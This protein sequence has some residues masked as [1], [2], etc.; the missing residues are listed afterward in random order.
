MSSSY[1]EDLPKKR[2]SCKKQCPRLHLYDS[3]TRITSGYSAPVAIS[4]CGKR[5][6]CVY[7]LTISQTETLEAE[8]FCNSNGQLE[9]KRTLQGDLNYPNVDGGD[10]SPCFTKFSVLDD[11]G[12]NTAR[13]RILDKNFNVL[14]T[15]YFNDYYAPGYSF[16]GGSFSEDGSMIAVTYVFDPN[17]AWPYQRSVLRILNTDDLSE[18]A[19]YIFN[20]NTGNQV[21]FFTVKQ[22]CTC[23]CRNKQYMIL[24][25]TGGNFNPEGTNILAPSTLQ[26]LS[27]N[28]N[29][30]SLVDEEELPQVFGFDFTRDDCGL[31][32][33]AGTRRANIPNE[34]IIQE[35]PNNSLIPCNGD[36]YRVYKFRCDKLF[37]TC[38]KNYNTSIDITVHPKY[39]FIALQQ[40]IN[41][42]CPGVFEIIKLDEQYCPLTCESTVSKFIPPN[43][44]LKF[45]ANG[46]WA[47]VTGSKPNPEDID[48]L[49]LHNVLLYKVC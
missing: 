28:Q 22:K 39:R 6:Y 44:I 10:A 42:N 4:K 43:A 30:I 41:S 21:K 29:N 32:I 7:D 47:I 38:K 9:T 37:L 13:L 46:R 49:G 16:N 45:S 48:M 31:V 35:T 33:F 11:D 34:K 27:L 18:V 20:G 26:I 24:T 40:S 25:S 36:E 12:I 15:K 14:V 17:V 3:I 5:I 19:S 1:L 8:L 23:K 2:G